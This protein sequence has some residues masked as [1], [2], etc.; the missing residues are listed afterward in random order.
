M[1]EHT[2]LFCCGRTNVCFKQRTKQVN[3]T[4]EKKKINKEINI[5]TLK[6]QN[7]QHE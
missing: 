4:N 6:K 5:K 7:K 1:N 3:K 2:Y